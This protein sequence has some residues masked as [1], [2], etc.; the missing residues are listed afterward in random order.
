MLIVILFVLLTAGYLG[1]GARYSRQRY[2]IE[3]VRLDNKLTGARACEPNCP[4]RDWY[5]QQYKVQYCK[6]GFLNPKKAQPN[7]WIPVFLWPGYKAHTYLTS[8]EAKIPNYQ[9]IEQMEAK[10]LDRK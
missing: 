6:C 9:Y 1:I 4:S 2:A 3:K 10:L 8:G 7:V 5:S